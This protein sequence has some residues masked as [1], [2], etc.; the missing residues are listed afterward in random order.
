MSV[1]FPDRYHLTRTLNQRFARQNLA[2]LIHTN[3]RFEGVTTSFAQTE[4][5]LAGQAVS[6]VSAHDR[7][8]IILLQ[9]GWQ[10]VLNSTEPASLE[11][12][13]R[14]NALVASKD[15]LF[16][17]ELRTGR[18]SVG[19]PNGDEFVPSVVDSAKEQAYWEQLIQDPDLSTTDK[20]IT[21]MYHLM[22]GQLFWDGNKR[23][24]TLVANKLMIDS[25]VGLIN[26]P[27]AHWDEWNGLLADYYQ[28]GEMQAIKRWTYDE[29]VHGTR[30]FKD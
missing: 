5:I 14:I 3:S 18:G 26:L 27:L 23:T 24:A 30:L 19:L 21:L 17:G 29:A 9:K 16:P 15:A 7:D 20:A 2:Q 28:T 22:R 13:K 1:N 10:L 11:F 4:A 25:G 8:V 12:A 6:G